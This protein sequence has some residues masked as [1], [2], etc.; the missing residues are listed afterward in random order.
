MEP[1]R[2]MN[3]STATPEA[4]ARPVTP[5]A[6]PVKMSWKQ[7][8]IAILLG[9]AVV[10]AV[11]ASLR[12]RPEPP[13]PVQLATA[14]EGPIT[15]KITGAG[16][17]QAATTVKV[18]SNISGDLLELAV[19]EGDRVKKGDLIGRIEARRYAAT[20]K[21]EEAAEATARADLAS[22]RAVISRLEGDLARMRRLAQT[23]NASTAELERAEAELSTEK[24]RAD[25]AS[26]RIA[27]ASAGLAEARHILSFSTVTAPM[28]GVVVTRHKQVGER[29]RGSELNEDPIVTIATLSSMEMKIEVGEHEVVHLREGNPAEVDVDALPD[30]KWKAEV[31][32]IAKNAN[33]KNPNTEAEVTTFP[34]RLALTEEVPG[35]LPGMS[36]QATISTE[37]R[38]KAVVVPLAAVTVR[39][40]RELAAGPE[41]PGEAPAGP[42]PGAAAASAATGT[43]SG[44]APR[45]REQMKKL[46]F[47]AEDGVAKARL[48]EIGLAS[49]DEIEI[50]SGVKPGEQIIVGPY[51]ALSR[52]LR[53][54]KSVKQEEQG[55]AKRGGRS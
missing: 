34:V 7:R 49:E 29:V 42:P 10:A 2:P 53:D 51:R 41:K 25:A 21:R 15:R 23:G 16:K 27:Q 50:V 18:S 9:V 19:Q 52:E 13:T 8:T 6:R 30:R 47:V 12:P 39:T 22:Q 32:E 28:S 46:V 3:D 11:V 17:L 24:A 48:V 26:E 45:R 55:G 43:P 31:I 35:A 37:R 54:G 36:G 1:A 44:T 4:P 5:R 33:V 20:V 14:R 40:E 38:E